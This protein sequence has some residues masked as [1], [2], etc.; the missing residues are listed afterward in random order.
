MADRPPPKPTR[1]YSWRSL[2]SLPAAA[3]V[4]P[5]TSN[6]GPSTAEQR[7]RMDRQTL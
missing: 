6:C 3:V 7:R 4:N 2:R 1:R 5:M